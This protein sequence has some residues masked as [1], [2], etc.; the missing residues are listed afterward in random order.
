MNKMEPVF[1]KAARTIGFTMQAAK[2]IMPLR[3]AFTI[4]ELTVVLCVIAALAG[5]SLPMLSGTYSIAGT[6][7]TQSTLREVS[8]ATKQYWSDCKLLTLDGT[9]TV[10]TEATRFQVCW[11]FRN[12]Q[13]NS[14]DKSFDINSTIGWNGPYVLF[15]TG[16]PLL[17]GDVAIIDA[18]NHEIII[19]DVSSTS[20][21]RDVRIVSGGPN[22]SIEIPSNV[23][24]SSLNGSNTGDDLYVAL[25]LQ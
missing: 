13:T 5:L 15:S 25:Q 11:L 16:S 18:W 20:I 10:A 7:T 1:R 4:V 14:S 21:P 9:S 19:Q 22:G 6:A 2:T 12:P 8:H 17:F 23:A 3:K 24:T